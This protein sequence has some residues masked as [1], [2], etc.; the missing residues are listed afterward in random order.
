MPAA[1]RTLKGW[2]K[3]LRDDGRDHAEY[4]RKET[5]ISHTVIWPILQ[6]L[7]WQN[8]EVEFGYFLKGD[9]AKNNRG[10]GEEDITLLNKRGKPIIF[11]EVKRLGITLDKHRAQL[12]RYCR[13]EPAPI[14]VLTNGF[15]WHFYLRADSKRTE[16]K[17]LATII[18]ID[19][20]KPDMREKEL[21]RFLEEKLR[22]FL[23]KDNVHSGDAGTALKSAR[24][25]DRDKKIQRNVTQAWNQLFEND[26]KPLHAAVKKELLKVLK[27]QKMIK[28]NQSWL[29]RPYQNDLPGFV[30]EQSEKIL[31]QQN[32]LTPSSGAAKLRRRSATT[33]SAARPVATEQKPSRFYLFNKEFEFKSWAGTA[34]KICAELHRRD[35]SLL[36]KLVDHIPSRFALSANN[37]KSPNWTSRAHL[38]EDSG[39]LI[40]LNLFASDIE[41]L[42]HKICKVLNLSGKDKFRSE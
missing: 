32:D 33:T 1:P 5:H 7:R 22:E 13:E 37:T 38:I 2:I 10:S 4:Q 3:K 24:K 30:K 18:I 6:A 25:T 8:D 31:L 21:R 12:L 9:A 17:A 29:P 40:N 14:G 27:S 16:D 28:R 20:N 23:D 41:E 11:I 42:C 19:N 36:R 34:K 15:D 26:G 35:P 39:V